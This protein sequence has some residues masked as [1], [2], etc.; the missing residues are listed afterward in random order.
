MGVLRVAGLAENGAVK[1]DQ[2]IRTDRNGVGMGFC[3][4]KRLFGGQPLDLL[5]KRLICAEGLV[6]VCGADCEAVE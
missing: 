1:L 6:D 3:S 5:R 4:G 2:C